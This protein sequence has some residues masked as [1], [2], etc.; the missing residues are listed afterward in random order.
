MSRCLVGVILKLSRQSPCSFHFVT[1][2][3]EISSVQSLSYVQ[4]FVTPWTVACQAYL[5]ITNTKS[6]SNS[7]PSSWWYHPI[8]SFSVIPFSC[9]QSFP[10]SG[11]FPMS[12]S[13]ASGGQSI[14]ASASVLPMIFQ[15]QGSNPHLLHLLHWQEGSLPLVL[16]GKPTICI[17]DMT[18]SITIKVQEMSWFSF[19]K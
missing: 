2:L 17:V 14:G 8:I 3:C 9:L 18:S 11:S 6:C 10:S 12:Q 5:S 15:D 7:C 19:C 1:S 4:L 16:P 13:F